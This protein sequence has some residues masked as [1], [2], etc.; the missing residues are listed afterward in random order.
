[1]IHDPENKRRLIFGNENEGNILGLEAESWIRKES[2]SC[3]N[4][5]QVAEDEERNRD[6][7]SP[8]PS[9]VNL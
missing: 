6:L 8:Q 1:L 5:I 9:S 3:G 4:E 2:G 7:T